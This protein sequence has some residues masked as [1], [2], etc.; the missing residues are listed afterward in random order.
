MIVHRG[1]GQA[2]DCPDCAA[3]HTG[4]VECRADKPSGAAVVGRWQE[5][6]GWWLGDR[7]HAWIVPWR[8]LDPEGWPTAGRRA[9]GAAGVGGEMAE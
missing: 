4:V 3:K 8:I 6:G 2:Q 7:F 9:R 5:L 1:Q